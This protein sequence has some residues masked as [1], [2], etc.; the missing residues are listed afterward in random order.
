MCTVPSFR[1]IAEV[2]SCRVPEVA[3]SVPSVVYYSVAPAVAQVIASDWTALYVPA[4]NETAGV[5]TF[6]VSVYIALDNFFWGSAP[7][8]RELA[9]GHAQ[10]RMG[11]K[12]RRYG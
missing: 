12:K 1:V 8:R 11:S 9:D 3:G 4:L 5:A 10:A 7:A 2:Y 6:F